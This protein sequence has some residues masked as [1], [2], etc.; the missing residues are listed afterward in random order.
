MLRLYL[1]LFSIF[2]SLIHR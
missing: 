2:L 1:L